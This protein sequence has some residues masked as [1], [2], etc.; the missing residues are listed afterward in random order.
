MNK[1]RKTGSSVGPL[2]WWLGLVVALLFGVLAGC[3]GGSSTASSGSSGSGDVTVSMTDAPGDFLAYTVDVTALQFV[4]ADG[5]SV[6]ALP[7]TTRIDFTQYTD[8]S[9]LFT[10]A[11]V[12]SG[13]YTQ[14]VMSLDYSNAD[15]EVQDS[16]GNA[17]KASLVDD[18]GNPLTSLNVTLDLP[19]SQPLVVKPGVPASLAL[20]FDLSASNQV[21][22]ESP[23]K[24]E[25]EPFLLADLSLDTARNH[26]AR[27]LLQQVDA[28]TQSFQVQLRP[29]AIRQASWGRVTVA[30]D[31]ATL[32]EINGV[33]YSGSAGLQQLAVLAT[34]TPVVAKGNV[35]GTQQ[36]SATEVLAGSSVP[37]SD[38]D[39]VEG[40]VIKRAGNVLTVRGHYINRTDGIAVFN[41]DILVDVDGSTVV[42]KLEGG[43]SGLNSGVISVG[44]KVTAFG[45]LSQSGGQ[46]TLDSTG[47]GNRVHLNVT[48]M[49]ASY[50]SLSGTLMTANVHY[51]EA[52][53]PSIFDFSG[54]GAS[55]ATDSNPANYH[56]DVT[57]LDLSGVTGGDILRVRGYAEPFGTV[58]ATDFDAVSLI[59][60]NQDNLAA[61]LVMRWSGGSLAPFSSVGSDSIVVNLSGS[62]DGLRLAGVNVDISG[63]TQLTLAARPAGI[64]R[65]AIKVQGQHGITF[66]RNFSDFSTALQS[67][68]SSGSSLLQLVSHGRYDSST[69]TLTTAAALAL[70]Q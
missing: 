14:V 35:S 4:K 64:G 18:S 46:Y 33:R 44:Q 40:V 3:G 25:V 53:V 37:W 29:F 9:E 55:S 50:T 12:P 7:L 31:S 70:V 24:V 57:G 56:V 63:Q 45:T 13:V 28:S 26:R 60:L 16:A 2:G 68:L 59:D 66:Y 32:Y 22:S 15:V 65:F 47:S 1:Q 34:N 30:T 11:T 67:Q 43:Q 27:G 23:A 69:Q 20:D 17:Q 8:L 38:K 19:G 36:L 21:L 10:V 5:T 51:I 6:S 48:Q 61:G 54:T 62:S 41:S 42:T 52:R 58:T 39:V 49:E